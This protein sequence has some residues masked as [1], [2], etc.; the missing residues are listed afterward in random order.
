MLEHLKNTCAH[1]VTFT[2]RNVVVRTTHRVRH[3]SKKKRIETSTFRERRSSSGGLF[4]F[5]VGAA[6]HSRAR[7]RPFFFLFSKI[8]RN[9]CSPQILQTRP[10]SLSVRNWLT[11]TPFFFLFSLFPSISFLFPRFFPSFSL[12]SMFFVYIY[13]YIYERTYEPRPMSHMVGRSFPR[14]NLN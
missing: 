11:F 6:F 8:R 5:L 12:T 10:T 7:F 4:N 2:Q 13:I 1:S 14:W 9:S 3:K